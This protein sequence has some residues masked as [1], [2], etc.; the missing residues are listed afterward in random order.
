MQPGDVIAGR[1]R[2]DRRVGTGGM[3]VVFRALDRDTQRTVAIKLLDGHTALDLERA[4][5]E[6][7]VLAR[8]VDPA[9]VGHV[10]DGVT[11]TGQVYLAMEWID[12]VTAAQRIEG[13]GFSLRE[14]IALAR[15]VAG[16][17][18][19]AHASGILHRDLKPSNVLL[20]DGDPA[21]AMLIDFGIARITDT[22]SSLTRT[23]HAVGTPGYMAPEQ[24]RGER[25]LG[26]AADVFG[27]GCLL[28]ECATG[29]PA[30]S[31]TA[32]VAV[33]VKILMA[34][35]LAIEQLCPEIGG[36]LRVLVDRLLCKDPTRRLPDGAAVAR[37]LDRLGAIA[38]GP[39]R[40]ACHLAS[41]TRDLTVDPALAHGLV[42]AAQGP[43]D[44]P[45]DPP[46]APQLAELRA[47]AE[48]PAIELELLATGGVVAHLDGV[49][50]AV[51][52]RAAAFALEW[53]RVLP[54]WSIAITSGPR[55][56]S[57]VAD[58][59]SSLLARGVMADL[60]GK[61][62][63]GSIAVDLEAAIHLVD[64]YEVQI[65]RGEA[66]LTGRREH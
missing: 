17:L 45:H 4:R 43:P 41:E 58:A 26:P 20:P 12:G 37:A 13:D 10:G 7:E 2:V 19:A 23:G 28:Y 30:F 34:E 44:E 64:D 52:L 38:D 40:S 1:F 66:R 9:I 36:E 61:A 56:L 49:A 22:V 15:R 3:G 14:T 50:R 27:L 39:R 48:G 29:Q 31:G 55:A 57:R 35:P 47:L 53:R 24:A 46:T 63:P 59:T 6:A 51:A 62:P 42:M 11:E 32:P 8:L 33:I 16:A 65:G 54:R 5:R 60:F 25:A 18:A 21:R